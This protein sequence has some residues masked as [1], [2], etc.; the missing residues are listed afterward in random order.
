MF[1]EKA[2]A[3]SGK[4]GCAAERGRR[5]S[6]GRLAAV[7]LA[8]EHLAVF[9]HGAPAPGPG[10]NVVGLHELI[11]ET[12]AAEGAKSLLALPDGEADILGKGAQVEVPLVARQDIGD[13]AF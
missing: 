9:F 4:S 6:L 5:R 12:L 10:H 8:A 2:P 13:D 3:L 7:A 1:S 11:V